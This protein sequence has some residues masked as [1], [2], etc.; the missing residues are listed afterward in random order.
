M[1]AA[2][3]VLRRKLLP[4]KYKKEER[5]QIHN[6]NFHFETRKGRAN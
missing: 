1:D 4:V 5:Y 6:L 3:A 2:K